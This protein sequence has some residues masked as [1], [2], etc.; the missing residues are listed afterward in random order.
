MGKD[1]FESC[2]I[3]HCSPTLANI[4]T[5]NLFSVKCSCEEEVKEITKSYTSIFEKKGVSVYLLGVKKDYAL[6]YVYR[7]KKLINDLSNPEVKKYLDSIGYNTFSLSQMLSN[8]GKRVIEN[9]EFPHEIGLFLGYPFLDVLGFIENMGKN[10]KYMGLW[11]V[12]NNVDAALTTFNK[13]NKCR[14]VYRRVFDLNKDIM[15]LT[16]KY[17]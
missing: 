14:S 5:A 15:K 7:E 3:E 17:V 13:Y 11:K 16:V 10:Y 1:Y 12:Y 6:I 4:K 9:E 8:L 2:L